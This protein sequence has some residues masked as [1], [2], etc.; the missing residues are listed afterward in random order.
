MFEKYI[1]KTS[2]GKVRE[3]LGIL[4]AKLLA[5]LYVKV[6]GEDQANVFGPVSEAQLVDSF[7]LYTI[8]K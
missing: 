4:L 1:V 2:S 7:P 6:L 5:E 3:V 8:N